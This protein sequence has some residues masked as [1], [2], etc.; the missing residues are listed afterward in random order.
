MKRIKR[1]LLIGVLSLVAT[2]AWSAE[3]VRVGF[4]MALT[5]QFSQ[6]A[7]SQMNAYELWRERVNAAGGLDVAGVKRPVEFVS[8]DDKSDPGMALRIYE[9]LI[10]NDKID[11]LLAPWGTPHHFALAALLERHKFPM[12]GNSAASVKL[13]E[14]K[15]G[16]IWFVTSA[17]PDRMAEELAKMLVE[18]SATTVALNTLQLP[19]SLEMRSFLLPALEKAKIKVVSDQQYPPGTDDLSINLLEIKKTNPDAVL[20]LSYPGDSVAYLTQMKELGINVPFQFVLIGPAMD[21]FGK[22]FGGAADGLVTVG[23]WTWHQDKW[24]RGQPFY[25]AYTAKY[26]SRPDPLDSALAY[27]SCEILEQAVAKSGLDL[28]KLRDTIATE[29]FDTINGP[30]RFEGVENV[31]TPTAFLQLQGGEPHL[32]WPKSISTSSFRPKGAW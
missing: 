20:S 23:H 14:I 26:N 30:V 24:P 29:Q 8:Y 17:I 22:I 1:A 31:I 16:Y 25:K 2:C 32:V 21:F 12:V 9:K 4:S 5:G 13:R 28:E 11:L 3:P 7:P 15:P 10:T 19:F 27:M 18:Q 6:A